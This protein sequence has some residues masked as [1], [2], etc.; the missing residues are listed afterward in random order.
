MPQMKV[1]IAGPLR[2]CFGVAAVLIL[3]ITFDADGLSI[4]CTRPVYSVSA[5]HLPCRSACVS[6]SVSNSATAFGMYGMK[7]NS[8]SR[9]AT[10]AAPANPGDQSG[11]TKFAPYALISGRY[12]CTIGFP[13]TP[14]A[15]Q[16]YSFGGCD[17]VFATL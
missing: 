11:L 3:P 17:F 12:V 16:P 6:W 4:W 14:R 8:R 9:A 2:S 15:D 5:V 7:L 10:P 13:F 1:P